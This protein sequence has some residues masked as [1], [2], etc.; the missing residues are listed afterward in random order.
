M[1]HK[2]KT[3][4]KDTNGWAEHE[5]MLSP[6]SQ[7]PGAR[8]EGRELIPAQVIIV[9]SPD[10]SGSHDSF[11]LALLPSRTL[12]LASGLY[13]TAVARYEPLVYNTLVFRVT[14]TGHG[15]TVS[16]HA[17]QVL[18]GVIIGS[19]LDIRLP[20]VG[21]VAEVL[22]SQVER[23]CSKFAVALSKLGPQKY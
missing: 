19:R 22:P 20:L 9:G 8:L 6:R 5:E 3:S 11:L 2:P 17:R 4:E 12:V 18:S 10:P 13:G 15:A 16:L 23:S 21:R 14:R 1:K 7:I